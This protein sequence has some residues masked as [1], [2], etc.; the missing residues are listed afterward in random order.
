MT[1]K[2]IGT[3]SSLHHARRCSQR[4]PPSLR[5]DQFSRPKFEP[6]SRGIVATLRPS[7]LKI[8]PT[9]R[10]ASPGR[11]VGEAFAAAPVTS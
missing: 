5:P 7:P 1:L 10:S 11:A 6:M 8:V 3:S 2:F 9:S 4:P